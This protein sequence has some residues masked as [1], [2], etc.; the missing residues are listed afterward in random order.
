MTTNISSGGDLVA[1][2]NRAKSMSNRVIVEQY[3]VGYDYRLLVVDGKGFQKGSM[4]GYD[5]H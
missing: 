3:L 4:S 1:A 2:F 5:H